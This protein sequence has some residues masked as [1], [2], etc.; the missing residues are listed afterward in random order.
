M[1]G[2]HHELQVG[3]RLLVGDAVITLIFEGRHKTKVSVVAPRHVP[4][5]R[6]PGPH[7]PNPLSRPESD[8]PPG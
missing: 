8:C 6:E 7:K 5:R 2:A 3:D 1:P 4:I